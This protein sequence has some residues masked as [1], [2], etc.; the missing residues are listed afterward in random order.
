MISFENYIHFSKL[1]I[2]IKLKL[3]LQINFDVSWQLECISVKQFEK[4]E[5]TLEIDNLPRTF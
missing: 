5:E 1:E 2:F 3:F 4:L